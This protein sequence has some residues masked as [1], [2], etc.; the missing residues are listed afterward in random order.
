MPELSEGIEVEVRR[1]AIVVRDLSAILR[2]QILDGEPN[3]Q[4]KAVATRLNSLSL[5]AEEI[6][7]RC[8]GLGAELALSV[9]TKN[10][11][12]RSDIA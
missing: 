1:L 12:N 6:A 2:E 9:Q 11:P 7:D 5:Q 4:W 10:A 3:D 8:S